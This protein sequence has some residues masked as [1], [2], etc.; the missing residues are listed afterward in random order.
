MTVPQVSAILVNYNA[1][2]E[3]AMALQSIADDMAERPWE[4]VVVD[5]ASSDGSADEVAA[6]APHAR[7]VQNRQNVGFARGVNQGLAA[8]AAPTVLIMNPDC[9]LEQGAFGVLNG[10]L[11]RDER[12]ALVGPRILNPDG[13]VQ[14][15]ARGDPDML[16]GLFG[17]STALRRALPSLAVSKRNV[18]ADASGASI[19][20]DWVSGACML[21]R[22]S[23]LDRVHGFDERYFLYWEDADL[24]RRLRGEGYQIRYVPGGDCHSPCRALQPRGAI[25]RDPRVSRERLPVLLDARRHDRVSEAARGEGAAGRTLLAQAPAV[26]T[27]S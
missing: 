21:A 19:E 23:A 20:V 8:T 27:L 26:T 25:V 22:R 15:S 10:E 5:N 18:V 13:S 24:C 7:V 11:Q 14:G 4:A 1:G 9:R 12:V 3:L 16:T 17:R 6:F 2:R